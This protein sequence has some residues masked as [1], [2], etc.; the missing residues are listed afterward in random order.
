MSYSERYQSLIDLV[1]NPFRGYLG[2]EHVT[3]IKFT[4]SLI[5]ITTQVSSWLGHQWD[6]VPNAPP[7]RPWMFQIDLGIGVNRPLIQLVVSR[8]FGRR[9]PCKISMQTQVIQIMCKHR[10]WIP[11][12]NMIRGLD[13]H[14]ILVILEH[15]RSSKCNSGSVEPFFCY[16]SFSHR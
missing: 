2:L 8:P 7:D 3:L 11:K 10:T 9:D 15:I 13:V 14:Q 16:A 1:L 5:K 12:W 4:S 6:G